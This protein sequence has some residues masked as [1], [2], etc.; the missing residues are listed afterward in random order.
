MKKLIAVTMA[1]LLALSAV[2]FA[3]TYRSDDMTFEYD[4]NAF[5]ITKD[6]RTDDETDVV[7]YG[8][9]EAWGHT[10]V[11]FYLKDLE[12]GEKFPTADEV[13]NA[14]D[15]ATVTEGEWNGYKNV[16]M[17]DVE[18]DDGMTRSFFV[19][20]VMDDDGNGVEDIL[21]VQI[22]TSKIDD[23]AVLMERD[24]AISAIVDSLK[25]ND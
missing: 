18:G 1:A 4:E 11:N 19:V 22:G 24:D 7:V 2:A 21:T 14:N 15:N 16:L 10:Y 13:S 3:E 20:P 25:V 8:K 5:E 23:E 9:S 12:D 6:D 17:Y